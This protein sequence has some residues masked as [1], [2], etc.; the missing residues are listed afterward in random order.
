VAPHVEPLFDPVTQTLTYV[1]HDGEDAV[2]IDA[3]LD[4]DPAAARTSTASLEK[5]EAYVAARALTVHWALETH[6][7]ADH[8]S[9]GA[10]LRSHL[11]AKTA[12]G[13][14]I[15]EV[16]ALFRDIYELGHDFPIDG[17]QFDRLLGDGDAIDAG[18]LR[19]TVMAIPG[20][21]PACVAYCIGDAV[22]TGDALF[23]HDYGTGRCDFPR[24][25]APDLYDSIQR[26]Y[27]L[28]DETRVFPA[29]DYLP[30]GRPLIWQTTIGVSKRDN[31]QLSATTTRE[32]FIRFR[33]QRDL[34][35]AAPRL[36]WP[37]VQVNIDGGRL[38][39]GRVLKIP[40]NR[41]VPTDDDGTPRR[42]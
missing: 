4:Y 24:G 30:G 2:V 13:A 18:A 3:V 8:L 39:R 14:R 27:F 15:V 16:Q 40:L 28:P 41:G 7:H 19:I 36:L 32:E 20:H 38:P 31:V 17:R 10:W 37:S 29:H 22:F 34:T 12:I 35:L 26:L 6:P 9:G 33:H 23:I 1:V 11:G 21:T 42:R 25:S 5:V